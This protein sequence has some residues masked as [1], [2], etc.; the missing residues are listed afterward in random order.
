MQQAQRE[1]ELVLS[2][3]LHDVCD[4]SA[5]VIQAPEWFSWTK[6]LVHATNWSPPRT[7]M[8]VVMLDKRALDGMV[9]KP[10]LGSVKVWTSSFSIAYFDPS[11][12]GDKGVNFWIE[13]VIIALD[14]PIIGRMYVDALTCGT[15]Q[16]RFDAD[17]YATR[18]YRVDD[19][20]N[21]KF[22]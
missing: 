17:T 3:R 10:V 21:L 7:S 6:G 2:C 11:N 15:T 13:R 5:S 1:P 20:Y 12:A 16:I 8:T 18:N 9:E 4:V 22:T 14:Q 19:G